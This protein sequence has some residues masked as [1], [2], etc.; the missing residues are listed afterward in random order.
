MTL[1]DS[2]DGQREHT[3]AH[4]P[5]SRAEKVS[6]QVARAIVRQL[7]ELPRGTSLP[8]EAQM[9]ESFGASR[10][11]VRE[12][13]RILEVQGLITIRPGPGGGPV[14]VGPQSSALGRTATLFFHLL[15]ARYAHLLHAQVALEPL[16][17]RLAATNPDR[18]QVCAL[19]EFTEPAPADLETLTYLDRA[20]AFHAALIAASGN[21]VLTLICQSLRDI[22]ED[23]LA[24]R[25]RGAVVN[26]PRE[27][28]ATIGE[29][30]AIAAA[31]LAGA[32]DTAEARM[33]AHM[34]AYCTR[35][36]ARHAELV[37]EIVDW[38]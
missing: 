6:V 17:A 23:R 22:A 30:Q 34:E 26:D 19:A 3:S 32:A 24:T 28:Q 25:V 35:V 8:G 31:I 4:P 13:L 29:H 18:E 12:A 15:Q 38:H 2:G 14:L 9:I 27:R 11:S 16:L 37:Q 20:T 5:V 7:A 21:P 1:K 10:S 33:A 36:L